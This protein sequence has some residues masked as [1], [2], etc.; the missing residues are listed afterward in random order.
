MYLHVTLPTSEKGAART[1]HISQRDASTAAHVV[2]VSCRQFPTSS[3]SNANGQARNID[4]PA[5]GGEPHSPNARHVVF[6]IGLTVLSCRYTMQMTQ[7][8]DLL[9]S[10]RPF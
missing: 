2:V 4:I 6:A 7:M 10:T 3:A 5:H 9:D 8:I 1:S